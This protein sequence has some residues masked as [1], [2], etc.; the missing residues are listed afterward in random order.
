MGPEAKPDVR[1]TSLEID[2]IPVYMVGEVLELL[3]EKFSLEV[4]VAP[5]P[6]SSRG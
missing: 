2:N 4:N 1:V 6:P 3:K 5:G